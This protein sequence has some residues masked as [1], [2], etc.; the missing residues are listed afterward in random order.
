MGFNSAFKGLNER[1]F[2]RY[3][4]KKRSLI[5]KTAHICHTS[6][7]CMKQNSQSQILHR[8]FKGPQRQYQ[9]PWTTTLIEKL[10]DPQ[11]V[12]K[13][14]WIN[15]PDAAIN[16][17][18]IVCRLDTAQHVS[19]ILMPVIRNLSTAAA[20]D[21]TDHSQ[22]HCYHHVPTVNQRLLLQQLIGSWWWA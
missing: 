11:P 16:Y 19:G 20:A 4:T 9:S 7:A 17:R 8:P 3:A 18:F 14:K 6:C 22:Q 1:D 10:V 5:F 2:S 15:Q 21:R 12:K 13:F